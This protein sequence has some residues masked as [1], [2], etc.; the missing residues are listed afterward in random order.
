[1]IKFISQVPKESIVDIYGKVKKPQFEIKS[2]SVKFLEIHIERF[3]VISRSFNVLP[4][5]LEDA[6]RKVQDKYAESEAEETGVTVKMKTRLDN[7][8]V[9]LRTPASQATFR[10]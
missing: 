10:I 3:Y 4:L 7:R 2:C 1:M 8:S 9:D 5:Q 6:S